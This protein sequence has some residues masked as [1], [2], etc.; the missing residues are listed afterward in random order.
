MEEILTKIALRTLTV[1]DL[2]KF[3]SSFQELRTKLLDHKVNQVLHEF[4]IY[5]D[6]TFLTNLYIENKQDDSLIY[7]ISRSDN[8]MNGFSLELPSR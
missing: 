5:V 4:S 8:S 1:T 2:R 3:A 6:T 7:I